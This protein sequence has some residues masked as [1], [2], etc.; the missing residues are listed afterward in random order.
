M[1]RIEETGKLTLTDEY[2]L[3]GHSV[4]KL[5]TITDSVPGPILGLIAVLTKQ[6]KSLCTTRDTVCLKSNLI[7]HFKQQRAQTEEKRLCP[8]FCAVVRKRL[9]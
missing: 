2:Q 5:Y 3:T 8:S 9:G 7:I 4:Q 6:K 1:I